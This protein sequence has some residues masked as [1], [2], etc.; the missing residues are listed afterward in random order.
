MEGF[1]TKILQQLLSLTL[2]ILPTRSV[3][4]PQ[5]ERAGPSDPILR[6]EEFSKKKGTHWDF[7]VPYGVWYRQGRI[8]TPT[9]V[10]EMSSEKIKLSDDDLS[11]LRRALWM[12]KESHDQ[13]GF[14]TSLDSPK[15][16][17]ADHCAEN[18]FALEEKLGV[19]VISYFHFIRDFVPFDK[20]MAP[21]LPKWKAPLKIQKTKDLMELRKTDG[22]TEKSLVEM[23]RSFMEENK[24][25]CVSSL[26]RCFK[27]N[28]RFSSK[29]I[30]IWECFVKHK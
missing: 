24:R 15:R 26:K 20:D 25:H 27:S 11:T 28:D 17:H 23:W 21:P 6:P 7:V 2:Y 19:A 1:N 8:L 9:F 12:Y 16:K 14:F 13:L 10:E 30:F 3:N 22:P 29:D 18:F 4:D 5:H